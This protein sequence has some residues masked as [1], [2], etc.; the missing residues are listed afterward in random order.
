MDVKIIAGIGLVVATL[1]VIS[2]ATSNVHA[3]KKKYC[4]TAVIH[5][6]LVGDVEQFFCSDSKKACEEQ[7][8]ST[9]ETVQPCHKVK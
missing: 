6:P 5:D 4:F 3:E 9:P 7:F 8:T 2:L 1:F